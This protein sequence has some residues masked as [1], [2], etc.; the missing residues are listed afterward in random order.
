MILKAPSR[1]IMNKMG[2]ALLSLY[3][4]DDDPENRSPEVEM[5]TAISII[6]KMPNIMVSAYQV[7]KRA[8][9]NESMFMHPLIP[10]QSTAEMIL[11]ALRPDRK[12]T[13]EE[14]KLLDIML[15][16]SRRARRR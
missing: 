7:K 15:M 8:Y 2:R 12:F 10:G 5:A 1:N 16:L 14:A 9:D 6:S 13:D 4:Y 3:S 11:S